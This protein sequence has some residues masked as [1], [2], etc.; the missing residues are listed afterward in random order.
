MLHIKVPFITGFT[1]KNLYRPTNKGRILSE[2]SFEFLFA[3]GFTIFFEFKKNSS[4]HSW[5]KI[6]VLPKCV[7]HNFIFLTLSGKSGD[8]FVFPAHDFFLH[9]FILDSAINITSIFPISFHG[10]ESELDFMDGLHMFGIGLPSRT[11]NSAFGA[12][13][14][15]IVHSFNMIANMIFSFEFQ[16]TIVTG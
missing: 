12:C 1:S 6:R 13:F 16:V 10:S 3:S 7:V 8:R 11:F 5:I 2:V 15:A 9:N 14:D 4:N